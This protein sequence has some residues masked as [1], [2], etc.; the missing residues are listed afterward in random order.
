MT[1]HLML[2]MHVYDAAYDAACPAYAAYNAA[3]AAYAAYNAS[4]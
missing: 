1:M 3:N 4:L 2:M